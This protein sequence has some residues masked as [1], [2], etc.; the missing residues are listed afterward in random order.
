MSS[1]SSL[2][3]SE[4]GSYFI[5]VNFKDENGIA[6]TPDTFAWTLTDRHGNIINARDGIVIA[7]GDLDISFDIVLS[8]EDL[9]LADGKGATRVFTIEGVYTSTKGI[10]PYTDELRFEVD[11][12]VGIPDA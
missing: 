3:A 11:Q 4:K 7:P 5:Q 8:G 2:K 1:I 10:L 6:A 9:N 12:R